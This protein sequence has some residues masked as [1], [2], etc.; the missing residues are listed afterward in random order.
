M[1]VK[2]EIFK[3]KAENEHLKAHNNQLRTKVRE[4]SK[5]DRKNGGE[6]EGDSDN[7]EAEEILFVTSAVKKQV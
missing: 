7:E 4:L 5:S 3:L 2:E 1:N 6:R